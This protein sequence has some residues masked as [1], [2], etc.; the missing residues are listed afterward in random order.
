[1][2]DSHEPLSHI[3]S[4]ED[5]DSKGTHKSTHRMR[6]VKR[7]RAGRKE[8]LSKAVKQLKKANKEL[9]RRKSK[10]PSSPQRFEFF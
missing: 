3:M 6:R 9:M 7:K 1:M 4:V 2:A 5:G 10:T 8:R